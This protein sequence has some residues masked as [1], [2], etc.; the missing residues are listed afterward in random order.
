MPDIPTRGEK[1]MEIEVADRIGATLASH[2]AEDRGRALLEALPTELRPLTARI[3]LINA[4][5]ALVTM[6][7]EGNPTECSIVIDRGVLPREIGNLA[8]GYRIWYMLEGQQAKFEEARSLSIGDVAIER[9]AAVIAA[10]RVDGET[11]R[12][13][14]IRLTTGTSA[15][16]KRND[17]NLTIGCRQ[18]ELVPGLLLR[19]RNDGTTMTRIRTGRYRFT[20]VTFTPALPVRLPAS[21]LQG[22][23]GRPLEAVTDA[24]AFRDSGLI[25]A[26]AWDSSDRY[27]TRTC[28]EVES[29]RMSLDAVV[30]LID[31]RHPEQLR[32]AEATPPSTTEEGPDA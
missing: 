27:A 24:P 32:Y 7:H 10:T 13:G 26:K 6:M 3:S 14:M 29:D 30:S 25:V 1:T 20:H 23:V 31:E 15:R 9:A 4:C 11:F 8:T 18:V 2:W 22:V 16:C 17:P 19:P 21:I 12:R 28:F 5:T